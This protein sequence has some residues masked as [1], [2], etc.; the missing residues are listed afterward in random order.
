MEENTVQTENIPQQ[1]ESPVSQVSPFS[2]AADHV[3]GVFD[4]KEPANHEPKI[5][6]NRFVSEI[7][8]WYEKLRNAMDYRDQEVV[9][10]ASVER[11]LK[12]R[13]GMIGSKKAPEGIGQAIAEPLLKELVWGHY[14][15]NGSLPESMIRH[16]ADIIDIWLRWRRGVKARY[17][18]RDYVLNEW[19][20]QLLSSHI[21]RFLKPQIHRNTVANF[22]F[23][24]MKDEVRITDDDEETKHVQVYLA[25]RRAYAKDDIAFLRFALFEQLFGTLSVHTAEGAIHGFKH[26]YQEIKK[27]LT[28]KLKEKIY[29]NVK[30]QAPVFLILE[31]VLIAHK[32]KVAEIFTKEEEFQKVVFEAAEKRYKGIAHQVRIAIVRSVV[33]LLVTKAIFALAIEGSYDKYVYGSISWLSIWLNIGIPPLLLIVVSLFIT[34][35]REDNSKRI[36]DKIITVLTEEEPKIAPVF[37]VARKPK[38]KPIHLVFT[39]LWFFAF[40]LSFGTMVQVLTS[41]H[42]N[43]VSQAVFIFFVAIVSFLSYGISS[44]AHQYMVDSK[45]GLFT[46]FID[47]LFI[48]IVRVGR[49]FTDGISSI[50]VIVFL[51]DYVIE[52]P[53]KAIFGFFDQLFGYLHTK[54]EELE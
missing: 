16:T 2:K 43:F 24:V 7:A 10:R 50:N 49:W 17:V 37:V 5:T 23:Y 13:L 30:K 38:K 42:F 41:L 6:V 29:Q 52:I 3:I 46:P 19:L 39:A 31:D 51:F 53:F 22:M 45:P 26:G 21:T 12:R 1:S 27:Q 44:T 54:R 25:C 4:R 18:M 47:F 35:P 20:Y 40:F 15:P 28:Y 33:F 14:F 48:P 11:I 8:N 36:L 34:Q 9:L 32:G